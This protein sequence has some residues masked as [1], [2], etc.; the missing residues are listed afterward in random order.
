MDIKQ[1]MQQAQQFQQNM[2]E[3]QEGLAGKEVSSSVGGGMVKATVNGKMEL[4]SLNIEK[5]VID[6]ADPQMLQDLVV[7]AVNEAM[8]QAQDMAKSEMAKLTGGL[9][10]PGMF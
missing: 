5:D 3:V 2:A 10:I 8:R 6:P 7:A 4:L 1:I 9:N